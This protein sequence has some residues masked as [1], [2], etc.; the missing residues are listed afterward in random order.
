MFDRLIYFCFNVCIIVLGATL[1]VTIKSYY[2][3][4]WVFGGPGYRAEQS[5]IQ[6]DFNQCKKLLDTGQIEINYKED[7]MGRS[8]LHLTVKGKNK[9]LIEYLIKKGADVNAKDELGE[10]P[11]H[12][13]AQLPDHE[14]TEILLNSG[15]NVHATNC[16]GN[17]AAHL[18]SYSSNTKTTFSLIDRG[19]KLT[20]FNHD[21]LTPIHMAACAGATTNLVAL[22]KKYPKMLEQKSSH[23][24]VKGAVT[25]FYY[26]VLKNEHKTAI[27]LL[28]LGA[29][30][31]IKDR[32]KNTPFD[33]T[34]EA[35]GLYFGIQEPL[36][37]HSLQGWQIK[38]MIPLINY[39]IPL[40]TNNL[41]TLLKPFKIYED[42]DPLSLIDIL[43]FDHPRTRVMS[44]IPLEERLL[45]LK[46]IAQSMY[47]S[48]NFNHNQAADH[49]STGFD[50]EVTLQ[51]IYTQNQKH[52]KNKKTYLINIDT[53][54]KLHNFFPEHQELTELTTHLNKCAATTVAKFFS[55]PLLLS[56][57]DQDLLN[58]L[59]AVIKDG[60]AQE[61]ITQYFDLD[62]LSATLEA[63]KY[64]D[65]RTQ[66]THTTQLGN[67]GDESDI[68]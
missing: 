32:N 6:G 54:R 63:S 53:V 41:D 21:G 29:K 15:A 25:P 34:G 62:S 35:E 11:L 66:E 4:K 43:M 39:G 59:K 67:N 46:K 19:A 49:I 36:R 33:I 65:T 45:S 42:E 28:K 52:I 14:I 47:E 3:I 50:F 68:Q 61:N 38:T 26:S 8:L 60:L 5:C 2:Y 1:D 9:K 23:T 37:G 20:K 48:I 7:L 24:S 51:K 18:A 12:V 55:H 13:A 56:H 57:L 17:T 30:Y 31:D 10:T 40:S 58:K 22:I 27:K 16:K 64:E 44:N